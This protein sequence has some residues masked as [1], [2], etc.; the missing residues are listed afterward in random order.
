MGSGDTLQLVTLI[1]IVLAIGTIRGHPVDIDKDKVGS[2]ALQAVIAKELFEDHSMAYNKGGKL[3]SATWLQTIPGLVQD[4]AGLHCPT[5]MWCSTANCPGN[6]TLHTI[7]SYPEVSCWFCKCQF[8]S[9]P[10]HAGNR[11]S[12]NATA[13]AH[14]SLWRHRNSAVC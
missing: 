2:K 1:C 4:N 11:F 14:D 7:I 8:L 5:D 6:V 12:A 9:M 13:A 10:D 3:Q